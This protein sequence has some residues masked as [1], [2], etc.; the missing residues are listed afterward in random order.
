MLIEL[1]GKSLNPMFIDEVL[2]R[3]VSTYDNYSL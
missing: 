1:E 2:S 3:A